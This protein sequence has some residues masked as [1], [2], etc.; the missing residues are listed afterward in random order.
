MDIKQYKHPILFYALSTII[1]WVLWFIVA[2]ISHNFN[3]KPVLLTSIIGLLGLS[4]PFIIALFLILPTEELKQDFISRFFNFR[5]IKLKYLLTTCLLMPTSILVA[6][7][8]STL[9]GYGFE[10]FQITGSYTFTSGIFPVWFLLIIAPVIEELAWHSYGTD[11]LRKRFNLFK[12][13]M[14]FALFWGLWHI[15]LSFIKDYYQSNLVES[16]FIYS[17]NF[18][19]SLF[20]FVII[21]N[22]LYYKTN[23]NVFIPIIFHIT[24]GYFNEVF[25]THP[26][27]KVIQT[28]LLLLLSVYL[29]T[30]DKEFFFNLKYIK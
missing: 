1:P 27:S 24:A 9:F 10:Q 6:Q 2:Y 28:I 26:M 5:T 23:R 20:P 7:L 16:G 14:I 13:S 25:A 12:T 19:V 18:I 8:I 22:W 17:L 30:N 15:P 4:A 21:M 3:N 11:C 29:I